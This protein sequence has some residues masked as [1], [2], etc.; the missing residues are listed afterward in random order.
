MRYPDLA[1]LIRSLRGVPPPT[2][3]TP[4]P[5][6]PTEKEIADLLRLHK[7]SQ[8]LPLDNTP[9]FNTPPRPISPYM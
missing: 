2:P 9:R 4:T 5:S 8:Q 6:E 7:D 3:Q 1:A